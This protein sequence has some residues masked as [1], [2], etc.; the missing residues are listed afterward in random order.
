MLAALLL[1]PTGCR[2]AETVAAPPDAT[3]AT[4]PASRPD[5]ASGLPTVDVPIGRETFTLEVADDDA[6]RERGLMYRREMAADRGMLFVFPDSDFRSFWMKNTRIP[7]DIL[8]LDATGQVVSVR[9]MVPHDESGVPSGARAKF[10][11]ELNRGAAG[12]AGVRVGDRVA[13]P[14]AEAPPP[15]R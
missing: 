8:Y 4:A 6:E 14:G 12:R 9:Q 13:V 7:L 11:V 1:A 10:A 5:A 15:V 2:D 3:A